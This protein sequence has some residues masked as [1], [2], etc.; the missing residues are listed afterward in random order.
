MPEGPWQWVIQAGATGALVLLLYALHQGWFRTSQEIDAWKGRSDR[1]ETQ[2]DTLLPAV[3]K[4]TDAIGAILP[5]IERLTDVVEKI[6]DSSR[7]RS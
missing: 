6:A 7:E 3:E 4:L 5:A 2:V 1:S